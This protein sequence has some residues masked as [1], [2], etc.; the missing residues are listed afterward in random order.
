MS[1]V[2]RSNPEALAN[3]ES[4][5]STR[6]RRERR[7]AEENGP[8]AAAIR[9][10][11]RA[12]SRS[13]AEAG[14]APATADEVPGVLRGPDPSDSSYRDNT[15]PGLADKVRS[16]FNKNVDGKLADVDW[17]AAART[18]LK[19]MT[20]GLAGAADDAINNKF[21][22]RDMQAQTATP[23]QG[24]AGPPAWGTPAQP[25]VE[26]PSQQPDEAPGIGVGTRQPEGP[27]G[28]QGG[29]GAGYGSDAMARMA[30]GNVGITEPLRAATEQSKA[31]LLQGQNA[32]SGRQQEMQRALMDEQQARREAASAEEAKA[33]V[34]GDAVRART[35]DEEKLRSLLAEASQISP[36]RY[37]DSQGG[38]GA[39]FAA[40]A[41]L[42]VSGLA[43][44]AAVE[45]TAANINRQIDRH[46]DSQ[47]AAYNAKLGLA[48]EVRA[49][50]DKRV[51]TLGSI[52]DAKISAKMQA[53]DSA[54]S[55]FNGQM[56]LAKTDEAKNNLAQLSDK[57]DMNL[58]ELQQKFAEDTA[59][60]TYERL[61]QGEMAARAA[62]QRKM[63]WDREDMIRH[64]EQDLKRELLGDKLDAQKDVA[65]MRNGPGGV[66]DRFTDRQAETINKERGKV[67]TMRAS[68]DSVDKMLEGGT[69]IGRVRSFLATHTKPELAEFGAD[70]SQKELIRQIQNEARL[71]NADTG[72][73]TIT[74]FEAQ[75][76]AR[77]A[78]GGGMSF[79][80]M[81]HIHAL[82]KEVAA[83]KEGAADALGT[84]EAQRRARVNREAARGK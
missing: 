34:V 81:K 58:A 62:A 14:I 11:R 22:N 55:Y 59:K 5:R 29:G 52:E 78:Q 61:H 57:L 46:V 1:W 4:R 74:P 75:L 9:A 10:L 6:E 71:L 83:A 43:G 3:E 84:P 53:I 56:Q 77:A 47:V 15:A 32:I 33:R 16:F 60:K 73:K 38:T 82:A 40:A 30:A 23:P 17:K 8:T 54:K 39:K 68:A 27:Q 36:E 12:D 24:P 44:P 37:W 42:L 76:I 26:Q 19:Y 28:G 79:E 7:E 65:G 67:A 50:W 69:E 49:Q 18:G 63:L 31:T 2:D 66:A 64:E 80:D 21:A 51:E 48:R 45:S 25:Q 41:G 70:E 72:G 13:S 35:A 20:G